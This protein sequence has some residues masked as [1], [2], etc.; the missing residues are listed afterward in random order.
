MEADIRFGKKSSAIYLYPIQAMCF[1]V[2]NTSG[3][4]SALRVLSFIYDFCLNLFRYEPDSRY[5][6]IRIFIT[7]ANLS[8]ISSSA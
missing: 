7:M 1:E 4:I 2:A 8:S 5:F 3:K 6:T